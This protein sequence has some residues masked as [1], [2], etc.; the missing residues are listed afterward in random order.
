MSA[1]GG[2]QAPFVTALTDIVDSANVLTGDAV[3]AMATDVF[4]AGAKPIAVARPQSVEQL[5][6]LVALASRS[7][8]PFTARGGGASYTDGYTA[9][10]A[11][12][13]L[14]DMGGLSRI[15]EI[16]AV[17]GYVSVEAGVTW[18]ALRD[19]LAAHDLRT[20]F[21]GPF[22]GLR[23]TIG[24]SM[25]QNSISHGSAAYGIS[26]D[27]VL[28]M[29]VVLADG[30]LMRTGPAAA[31]AK[32]FMRHFGPDLTGLFTGDCGALGIK[33]RITLPVIARRPA[34]RPISFA[35]DSFEAM[36]TSMRLIA[37]ERIEDTHFALDAAL[38]QGQIARQE[39]AGATLGMAL[40]VLRSSP[41][42]AAGV[43][44]LVKAGLT[45]RRQIGAAK[46][47]THYIVEG[48]DD[49]EVKARLHRIRAINQDLGR[50]IAATV[51][52]VVRGM[53]FA[54][55]Y[56]TLG[57]SGERWVPLHGN[58][59][60]SEVPVFHQAYTRLL[61]SRAEEMKAHGVWCG[62]MYGAIGSGGFLYEIAIYWPD[63]ITAYHEATVPA[64]YLAG[65]PRYPANPE[66]RDCATQLKSDMTDLLISHGAVNFQIGRAYPYAS[67]LN[68]EPLALVKAVK[69]QLD[70]KGLLAPGN[71]GL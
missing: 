66:A 34:H 22:S 65:L 57:P 18:S 39:R 14:I 29:D 27:S 64:D 43:R 38:S 3:T 58:L 8:I 61:E 2:K 52:A 69:A 50:E 32:P 47:M 21:W 36:H 59:P 23:A 31:G 25:S 68:E 44:Q 10:D 35:F 4:R 46:F 24:G 54:E 62:G 53:P 11:G 55:F 60:H 6:N 51:P 70:P 67:R 15:V 45:A 30:S 49:A 13:L 12:Q 26:A 5:Q 42:V 28:S 48:F 33:A 17:N 16:D 56:N 20:P 37:R 19:E 9:R 40:S 71:L 63:E 7:D 41:S 1:A